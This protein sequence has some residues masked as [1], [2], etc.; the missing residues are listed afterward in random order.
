M[1]YYIAT[2]LSHQAFSSFEFGHSLLAKEISCHLSLT[3]NGPF[4]AANVHRTSSR[5]SPPSGA[6]LSI[7]GVS[8]HR[9]TETFPEKI[10]ARRQ[11]IVDY[12]TNSHLT[13]AEILAV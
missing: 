3:D 10:Q 12:P 8:G 2:F 5:Y 7:I 13:R 6:V 9:V 1:L 4:M 11:V